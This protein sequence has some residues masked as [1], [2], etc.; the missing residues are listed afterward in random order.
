MPASGAPS[1]HCGIEAAHTL[2]EAA[3]GGPGGLT[4]ERVIKVTCRCEAGARGAKI[5]GRRACQPE[6]VAGAE[7]RRWP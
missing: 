7:A 2:L 3:S 1:G 5:W 4:E 6:E